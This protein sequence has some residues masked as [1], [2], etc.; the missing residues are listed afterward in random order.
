M[1]MEGP[2]L[3]VWAI[4]V[5]IIIASKFI[6]RWT[7]TKKLAKNTRQNNQPFSRIKG[8]GTDKKITGH[9][10]D[11]QNFSPSKYKDYTAMRKRGGK[12]IK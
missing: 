8:D 9:K 7:M 3:W 5:G 4:I 1:L 10:Y 6:Y 2:P 12:T 11:P